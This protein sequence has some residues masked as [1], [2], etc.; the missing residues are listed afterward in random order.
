MFLFFFYFFFFIFE[1]LIKFILLLGNVTNSPISIEAGSLIIKTFSNVNLIFPPVNWFPLLAKFNTP[2]F[3]K[4]NLHYQSVL[5]ATRHCD[6]SNSLMEFLIYML[7]GFP[8]ILSHEGEDETNNMEYKKLL[9]SKG[10]CKIIEL[11]GFEKITT[12]DD[13]QTDTKVVQKRGVENIA[14][15][16]VV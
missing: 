2:F 16:V 15:R 7:V 14:K 10:L 6:Y 4:Y 5:M 8:K 3:K 9:V 13:D 11:F 1:F 12:K